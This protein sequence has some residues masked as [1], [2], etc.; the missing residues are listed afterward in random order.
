MEEKQSYIISYDV[1][2]SNSFNY[3]VLI[4]HIK[5]YGYWAH[6]T[7]STWAILSCKKASEIRDEFVRILPKNSRCIVVQSANIAAWHNTLCSNDWLKKN[8]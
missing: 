7:Q 1:A 6:I 2:D 8:V 4:D 3:N 5:S